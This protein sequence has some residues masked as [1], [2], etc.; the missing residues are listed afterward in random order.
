M[1]KVVPWVLAT[2]TLTLFA[3]ISV[4]SYEDSHNS[5]EF[6]DAYADEAIQ[7]IRSAPYE[8]RDYDYRNQPRWSTNRDDHYNWCMGVK[9]GLYDSAADI[10]NNEQKQ[11]DD[12]AYKCNLCSEYAT[13][14]V[15]Q[16]DDYMQG[17]AAHPEDPQC[18]IDPSDPRWDGNRNHHM[19]WCMGLNESSLWKARRQEIDARQDKINACPVPPPPAPP[20]KPMGHA[21]P[22]KPGPG[23]RRHKPPG[24]SGRVIVT[25]PSIPCIRPPCGSESEQVSRIPG[26]SGGPPSPGKVLGPGILEGDGGFTR[27][28]PPAQG[29]ITAPTPPPDSSRANTFNRGR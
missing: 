7:K 17:V 22:F 1:S 20:P 21:K 2:T 25:S 13:T 19:A 28:A 6:C 5:K 9:A 24:G 10:V 29:T 11:R 16:L 3:N 23:A 15:R 14:A 27:N 12:L 8:C 18:R 4:A 26:P